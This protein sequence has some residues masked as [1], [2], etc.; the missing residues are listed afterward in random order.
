MEKKET[1]FY[2]K[3]IPL[4]VSIMEYLIHLFDSTITLSRYQSVSI[5]YFT[6]EPW[7][8]TEIELEKNKLVEKMYHT[9]GY[10]MTRVQMN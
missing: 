9:A 7:S 4:K 6:N 3:R 2:F 8:P 1:S 5:T 10:V